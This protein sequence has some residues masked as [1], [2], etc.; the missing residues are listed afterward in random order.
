M[1]LNMKEIYYLIYGTHVLSNSFMIA[2]Q[3]FLW[4]MPLSLL[5][6]SFVKK[7]KGLSSTYEH[8]FMR[9][10][11]C[12]CSFTFWPSFLFICFFYVTFTSW[13]LIPFIHSSSHLPSA[14][15]T[16]PQTKLNSREKKK[17]ENKMEKIKIE[18]NL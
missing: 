6:R 8:I 9:G 14:T 5:K 1:R 2:W 18:K 13:I 4:N 12:H 16:H 15:E 17:E 11:Q 10:F 7:S 3:S